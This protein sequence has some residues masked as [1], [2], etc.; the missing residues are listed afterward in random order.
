MSVDGAFILAETR[1]KTSVLLFIDNRFINDSDEFGKMFVARI[2]LAHAFKKKLIK[3]LLSNCRVT[4]ADFSCALDFE[5]WRHE[6]VQ[7]CLNNLHAICACNRK[8]N[9]L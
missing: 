5:P 9:I 3:I 7:C 8:H 2:A 6:L 1:R 4:S